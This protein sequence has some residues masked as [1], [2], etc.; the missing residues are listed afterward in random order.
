MTYRNP[1]LT[2]AGRVSGTQDAG[3]P[4]SGITP[5]TERTGAS[6]DSDNFRG[7]RQGVAPMCDRTAPRMIGSQVRSCDANTRRAAD[8]DVLAKEMRK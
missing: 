2:N 7:G 1:P 8:S 3:W 4:S 5:W 6:L